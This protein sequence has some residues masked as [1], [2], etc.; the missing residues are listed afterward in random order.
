MLLEGVNSEPE[1]LQ[2]IRGLLPLIEPDGIDLNTALR[3]PAESFA[4]PL[5]SK[6]ME[7][8]RAYLGDRANVITQPP[9]VHGRRQSQKLREAIFQ[10]LG[11]RPCTIEEISKA[12]G[13][14][15]HEVAKLVGAL[16]EEGLVSQKS[17]G[18]RSYFLVRKE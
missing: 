8:I 3:P 14:H 10:T 5:T 2:R 15:R 7:E 17:H 13:R 9:S 16:L 18:Q 6:K 12:L 1:E 4:E 11:R